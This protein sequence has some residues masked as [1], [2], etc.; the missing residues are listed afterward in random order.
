MRFGHF[1]A[2]ALQA[3]A[4]AKGLD[5]KNQ[6]FS[7]GVFDFKICEKPDGKFYGIPNQ[8][9]CKAPNKEA[10]AR[11]DTGFLNSQQGRAINYD[12]AKSQGEDKTAARSK[13]DAAKKEEDA[14]KKDAK[15]LTDLKSKLNAAGPYDQVG[16]PFAFL[17][18]LT[19]KVLDTFTDDQLDKMKPMGDIGDARFYT[20]LD[21]LKDAKERARLAEGAA[22]EKEWLAKTDAEKKKPGYKSPEQLEKEQ[23]A[24]RPASVEQ[25]LKDIP[26]LAAFW[27]EEIKTRPLFQAPVEGDPDSIINALRGATNQIAVGIGTNEGG[28]SPYGKNLTNSQRQGL[29]NDIVRQMGL[30]AP[31]TMRNDKA[32]IGDRLSLKTGDL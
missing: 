32:A 5:T 26:K 21:R 16:V 17:D 19:A 4:E 28:K 1:T 24:A 30:Q 14:R 25:A 31:G 7:E 9:K 11:P 8:A 23:A 27:K 22:F 29:A 18:K 15:N 10:A 20:F 2:E 12:T 13:E 6:D 3:F